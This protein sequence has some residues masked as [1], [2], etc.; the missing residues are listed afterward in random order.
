MSV[1]DL[2]RAILSASNMYVGVYI[3]GGVSCKTK[4]NPADGG[5]EEADAMDVAIPGNTDFIITNPP[6]TR[7]ILHPMIERF[8]N[9]RPT[10]LL[11]D[12]DWM[13]TKQAK[14]YLDYCAK[15]VPT[16]RIKWIED[17]PYSAKDNTAW[18]MF[19]KEKCDTLFCNG[20][21]S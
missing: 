17:S 16:P 18:F 19:Q 20:D 11:F 1:R 15:I 7:R 21:S 14:P 2:S 6:W 9:I 10:W 12:G 5:V 8:R 3:G 13:F 4:I